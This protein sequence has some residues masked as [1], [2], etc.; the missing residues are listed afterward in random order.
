LAYSYLLQP[1]YLSFSRLPA[2]PRPPPFPTRRSSDL[3]TLTCPECGAESRVEMPLDACQFFWTC[4]SCGVRLRPL[5]GDCCVFCSYAD[6]MEE[7]T[8]ELQS[9]AYLVCR[10]LLE[11]KNEQQ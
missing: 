3:A 10:L 4:P 7:H 9:L 2:P 11:K 6:Q 5:P 1:S 8:S